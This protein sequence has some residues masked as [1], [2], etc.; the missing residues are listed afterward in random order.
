MPDESLVTMSDAEDM[1]AARGA[2]WFNLRLSKNGGLIPTIQLAILARRHGIRYQLGCMVG[3]TSILS[4]A[5][6]WF[7]QMTPGVERAEG[8]FG[9]FL[10]PEDVIARPIRFGVGG[11]WKPMTGFGLG[12]EIDRDRL[13]RL[14]VTEPT[15]I[16]L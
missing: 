16:Q 9:K 4:A 11:R 1:I 2:G 14:A 5:A 7:L 13:R 12:I 15:V 8:S 6:R 3:E 10:M